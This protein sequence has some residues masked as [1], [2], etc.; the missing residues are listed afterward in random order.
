MTTFAVHFADFGCFECYKIRA[1]FSIYS[2]KL[3]SLSW[4]FFNSSSALTNKLVQFY[5]N[6]IL[7][8]LES[9]NLSSQ[10]ITGLMF[11][12]RVGLVDENVKGAR[13]NVDLDCPSCVNHVVWSS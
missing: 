10:P 7:C 1:F 6:R 2:F 5:T 4:L 9:T 11:R 8:T 13:K 12:S 3:T